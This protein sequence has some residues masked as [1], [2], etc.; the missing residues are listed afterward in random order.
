MKVAGRT[1]GPAYANL[2]WSK[3]RELRTGASDAMGISSLAIRCRGALNT[4]LETIEGVTHS[5]DLSR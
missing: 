5:V 4:Y 1:P 2:Q 3:P